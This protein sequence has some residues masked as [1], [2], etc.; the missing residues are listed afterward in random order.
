MSSV[1]NTSFYLSNNA[2]V[3]LAIAQGTFSSAQQHFSLFGGRELRN[4]NATFDSNYYSVQNPDVLSAVSAGVFAN[5]F[6]HF[7]AFGVSENRAPTTAFA[8]FDAAAYLVANTDVADAVTA[9]TISSALE[10]FM[11]F[12]SSEGRAGSGITAVPTNPGT[13]FTLEATSDNIVGTTGDDQINGVVV[14]DGA[15]G[16][17]L[18]A[19]DIIG[20]GTGTDTLDV[21]VSGDS[22]TNGHTIQAIQGSGIEKIT[23]GNF[24]TDA[25]GETTFDTT[26]L[27]D[28]LA[29]V[30]LSS[31]S[32][33]GDTTFTGMTSIVGAEMKNGS[34][35]LT[36]TYSAAAVAGT[37]DDQALA[38]SNTS[39]GTFTAASV[40]TVSITTSLAAATLATLTAANATALNVAGDQNLTITNVVDFA[41]N[42]TATATDGTV[43]ASGFTGAL[44]MKFDTGDNVVVTGGSGADT[45]DFTSGFTARDTVA[46]GAGSDTLRVDGN[47]TALTST[48]LANVSGVENLVVQSSADT[49]SLNASTLNSDI[50]T[51][52]V[53]GGDNS[54][55]I[56]GGNAGNDTDAATVF[57][58]NETTF[59][60]AVLG[61]AGNSAA[62]IDEVGAAMATVINASS[63]HTS[64]YTAGTDVL[65]V[66]SLTGGVAELGFTAGT[67]TATNNGAFNTTM[68]NLGSQAVDIQQGGT[69]SL[70]LADPSGSSDSLSINLKAN[71]GQT[72]VDR[73]IESISAANIETINL[74]AS[75]L[76]GRNAYT[77]TTL[78][79]GGSNALTTLNITGS[80]ELDLS[81][82][83]TAGKLA[84]IN[85]S[86]LTG[87]LSIDG[88]ATDQTITGGTDIDTFVMATTL[89]NADNITGGD[90]VDVLSATTTSLTAT[91]G[92][93]NLTNVETINL[94]N[95]G[96]Q[97]IDATNITGA[98]SINTLTNTT[99][100]TI[101][102]LAAGVAVGLGIDN[103]DGD[104]D[105]IMSVTLADSSG[106]ADS[107]TINLNDTAGANTSTV[108]LRVTA[109]VETVTLEVEDSTDTSNADSAIDVDAINA[110]SLVITGAEGDAAHAMGLATLDT[111]T[112]SLDATGY[113]GIVTATA[114]TGTATTFSVGGDRAHV[115]T[116]STGNDTFTAGTTTNADLTVNGVSGTDV[117]NVT[118]G[119]GAADFDSV[120]NI[121]TMNITMSGSAAVTLQANG[122][123]L[124]GINTATKVN[125]LGGNALSTITNSS[126]DTLI[127][128]SVAGNNILDFSGYS[129]RIADITWDEDDLDN[130]TAGITVQVIG[131]AN[132]DIVS[133]SYGN[134]TQSVQINTQAV[135]RLDIA[136]VNGAVTTFDMS[137]A[138]GL[139]TIN[140]TDI[141]SETAIINSLAAGVTVD[142]TTTDATAS[143]LTI[144]QA[145][146]SGSSDSQT[147]IAAAATGNDNLELTMVDIETLN[148]SSDSAGQVDLGLASVSMTA[149][150]ATVAVNVTGTND[151][152]FISTNADINVIDASTMGTGG[153]VV[154]SGRSRTDSA[155]YTGSSG[156]DTFIMI[157]TADTITG[158]SGTD[159]LDINKAAIL[160]GLNIDLSNTTDQI[161]SFNGS[162]TSGTV[163][164]FENALADG[165]TG[166]FGAQLTGSS[167][168]NTLT[169]TG[170]ADVLS[171]GAG[172]DTLT[173]GAGADTVTLGSGSDTVVLG[174]GTAASADTITGFSSGATASGGDVIDVTTQTSVSLDA[175][176][177]QGSISTG[178]FSVVAAA[179]TGAVAHD[180]GDILILSGTTA[181]VGTATL[182]AAEFGAGQSF[183]AVVSGDNLVVLVADTQ[184]GNTTIYEATETAN[185]TLTAGELKVIGTLSSFSSA[186][187]DALVAAN[188][189]L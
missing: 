144:A 80:S 9:G 163:L 37:A 66:R 6:A 172:N 65:A 101:T 103:T 134:S 119:A 70:S 122:D 143:N 75:G 125:F 85:A 129:G 169:G 139:T 104:V 88:S 108:D 78:T 11:S 128:A 162:A 35:N 83:V 165:Y 57:T 86:T 167:G 159:T 52:T 5:P 89:N 41:D 170:N 181:Q 55:S 107:L 111:D 168:A 171:G 142:Y 23:I 136:L 17:T 116:G 24:D 20:G 30:G 146:V 166:S 102:N 99:Q 74:D 182:V 79:D 77:V 141:S 51:V 124:D 46:G 68:T 14:G 120:S 140:L 150:G 96:T 29:T 158:G 155:T 118:L 3:V 110:A 31:S 25:T 76:T 164:G 131:T 8:G 19:G 95:G 93:L 132:T 2:D 84:T 112:T 188:F 105:G 123:V 90:G 7:Q 156:A 126:G 94:T 72:T 22:G 185:A 97:V 175:S 27:N 10:H 100:T 92:A 130:D 38:I 176:G 12:G 153:A 117:Y 21:S 98:T 160:G 87:R 174:D 127:G 43:D 58:I 69:V 45:F 157:N 63:T 183:E 18:L 189:G 4:P 135:E 60:T 33:T 54:L 47:A 81:G 184:T 109:G 114:G 91:T 113:S 26:L 48:V 154:Q 50:T 137:L 59:T 34:A 82:T 71:T 161:V 180:T 28:S 73:T 13:T 121:D 16:S 149:S 49:A 1:F 151:I 178:T 115:L 173:G 152:E 39:G 64:T 15:T 133:A 138:T 186:D 42:T 179:G 40:E 147:V 44:T 36:M 187:A 145:D 32:A 56:T 177:A 61:L 62:D 67:V 106:A 53:A 148:I